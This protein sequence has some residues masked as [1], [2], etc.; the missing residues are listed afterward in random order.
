MSSSTITPKAFWQDI[1]QS[2]ALPIGY[3]IDFVFPIFE[4]DSSRP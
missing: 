1:G 3:A 4:S 2:N